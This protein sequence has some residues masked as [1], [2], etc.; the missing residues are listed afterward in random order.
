M[1]KV[2]L[3]ENDLV[4]LIKRIIKE[5]PV[6]TSE[7]CSV[8]RSI[9]GGETMLEIDCPNATHITKFVMPREVQKI[10]K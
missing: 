7:N 1:K 8:S 2:R 3:T 10:P 4:R 6:E 5:Q 9:E